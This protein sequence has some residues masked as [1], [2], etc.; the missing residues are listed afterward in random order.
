MQ[1]KK[2]KIHSNNKFY[3]SSCQRSTNNTVPIS[4]FIQ[5]NPINDDNIS[6]VS[7][8]D[9]ESVRSTFIEDIS[10]YIT[11]Q[12]KEIFNNDLGYYIYI[13]GCHVREMVIIIINIIQTLQ[14]YL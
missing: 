13:H 1:I 12:L 2:D 11:L 9:L 3:N 4:I 10:V 6:L 14:L 5:C 7:F 8:N